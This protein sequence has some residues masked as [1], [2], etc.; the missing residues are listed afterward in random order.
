VRQHER[1]PTTSLYERPIM[2]TSARRADSTR[3]MRS[4]RVRVSSV[5]RRGR[6]A[7]KVPDF[8]EI[9]AHLADAIAFARVSHRSTTWT[10]ASKSS[11]Y[12][13]WGLQLWMRSIPK[14]TWHP[15]HFR[16]ICGRD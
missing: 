9:M 16:N 3:R 2:G 11:P 10:S 5:V 4:R 8:S 1:A 12:C 6:A 13:E 7:P 15:S 14:L